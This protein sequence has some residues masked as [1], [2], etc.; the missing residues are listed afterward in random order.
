MERTSPALPAVLAA[1]TEVSVGELGAQDEQGVVPPDT[2]HLSCTLKWKALLHELVLVSEGPGPAPRVPVMCWRVPCSTRTPQEML[3]ILSHSEQY[4][5]NMAED[6]EAYATH[7]HRKMIDETDVH[8]LMQRQGFITDKCALNTLIATYLPLEQR[9][10][11]I[12][13]ARSGN[14]L[15]PSH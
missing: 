5:K 3:A 13:I 12:P 9:Q 7:A 11:L 10:E 6:L 15:E 2:P 14:K 4:W 8:L 1:D